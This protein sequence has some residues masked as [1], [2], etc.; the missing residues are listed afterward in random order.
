MVRNTVSAHAHVLRPRGTILRQGTLAVLALITPLFAVLYWLT[1]PA[2]AW[3]PVVV[4]QIVVLLLA[5][6]SLAAFFGTSIRL[7]PGTVRERGFFG[8]VREVPLDRMSDI[9]LIEVYQGSALHTHSQLFVRDKDGVL[10]LRMRGQFWSHDDIELLIESLDLPVTSSLGPM[11]LAE[12]H[13]AHPKLLYWFE[14]RPRL[15]RPPASS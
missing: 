6:A 11:T 8:W 3:L 15:T 10:L 14:R 12:L 7:N 1:V 4:A 13:A 9:L 5:A 2:G